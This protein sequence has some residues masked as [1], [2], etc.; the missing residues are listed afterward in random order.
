MTLRPIESHRDLGPIGSDVPSQWTTA[1]LTVTVQFV[2]RT[3]TPDAVPA[4]PK[5]GRP[6]R[7]TAALVA[8][9]KLPEPPAPR[10]DTTLRLPVDF[11]VAEDQAAVVGSQVILFFEGVTPDQRQGILNA[12]LFAQLAATAKVVE[13]KTLKDVS[14]W[15]DDYFSVLSMIGFRTEE[16]GFSTYTGEALKAYKV[17]LDVATPLLAESPEALRLVKKSL[18]ALRK[19]SADSPAVKLFN[20]CSQSGNMVRFQVSLVDLDGNSRPRVSSVVFA[21]EAKTEFTDVLFFRF[22]RN[23]A[24]FQ[25]RAVKLTIDEEVLAGVREQIAG[26]LIAYTDDYVQRL[27]DL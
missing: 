17:V 18:E 27:P 16:E 23:E 24:T 11:D 15:Y 2:P 20:R 1:Q 19:M 13:P 7:T 26:K 6:A 14:A 21:L 9:A 5:L 10:V 25:H 4:D 3:R 12:L 22:R 8:S